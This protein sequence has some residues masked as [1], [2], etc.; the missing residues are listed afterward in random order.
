MKKY[1]IQNLPTGQAGTDYRAQITVKNEQG[2]VL[3]VALLLLLVA[4]V[5]G[6]TALST[7]TTKV[8]IAGNQRLSEINFSAADGG[9]SVST[10]IMKNLSTYAGYPITDP[11]FIDEP[12][13]DADTFDI[14]YTVGTT[15][16]SVDIDY[17]YIVGMPGSMKEFAC[18]YD[19]CPSYYSANAKLYRI[20]S[21]GVGA[22]GSES[23]VGTLSTYVPRY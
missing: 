19:Y 9:I 1:R 12:A 18:G 14:Q 4:T 11:N 5:V 6:I 17:L 13:Q 10:L 20:N 16:I 3:V 15:T 2:I 8:M 7:S 22:T 21:L 23:G